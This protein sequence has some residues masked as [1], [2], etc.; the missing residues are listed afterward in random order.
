[1]TGHSR[2]L[3]FRLHMLCSGRFPSPLPRSGRCHNEFRIHRRTADRSGNV[4]GAAPAREAGISGRSVR[5]GY[6]CQNIVC[7][8]FLLEICFVRHFVTPFDSQSDIQYTIRL[9]F[10]PQVLRTSVLLFPLYFSFFCLC[11]RRFRCF[12]K[13]QFHTENKTTE[14]IAA[15]HV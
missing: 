10:C 4:P 6:S 9:F 1:M 2:N 15:A 8:L 5:S 14:N 3:P 13:T 11:Y 12:S 7:W